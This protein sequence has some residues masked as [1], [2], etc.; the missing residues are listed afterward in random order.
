[1]PNKQVDELTLPTDGVDFERVNQFNI[2]SFT[3]I[4]YLNWSKHIDKIANRCS[5]TT[6]LITKLEHII[7][8][9]IK[10]TL[11]NSIILPHTNYNPLT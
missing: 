2:L 5:L 11:Y 10:L 6:G 1:M 9:R 8:I 7:Q 3:L 4:S